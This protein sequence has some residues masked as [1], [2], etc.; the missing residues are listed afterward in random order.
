MMNVFGLCQLHLAV[1]CIKDSVILFLSYVINIASSS[2]FVSVLPSSFLS[3]FCT[4]SGMDSNTYQPSGNFV[5]LLT[6]QQGG[7]FSFVEDSVQLSSSQVL[8][9]GSQGAEA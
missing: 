4:F 3:I 7:V 2:L 6:S 8:V 5:D 9:F 1:R